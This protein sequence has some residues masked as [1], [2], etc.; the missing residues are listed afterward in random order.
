M[1]K[2]TEAHRAAR[3]HEI[4]Q[5]ALRCFARNGFQGTSM[6][7]IIAESGLSAGAIYGHYSSKNEIIQLVI[8]D[9]LDARFL[10]VAEAR[11]HSPLPAPGE[12]IG[13]IIGGMKAQVGD[14]GMLV[15]VWGEVAHEPELRSITDSIGHR[16][17]GMLTD[18]LTAWYAESLG[19]GDAE[20]HRMAERYAPLYV[21]IVQGYV[22]QST[23]F[24]DFDS[25][26]YLAAA[27]SI[28]PA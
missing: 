6:A 5:A 3:R 20:A 15:Q 8:T 25:A 1:P 14:L 26:A 18:Y 21:G 4:S 24:D 7:D 12:I 27:S 2:V 11:T 9:V 22:T 16:V 23:L 28:R 17:R 19:A 13:L 10:E